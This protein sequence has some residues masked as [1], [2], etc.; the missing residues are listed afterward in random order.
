[1]F[2]N[3]PE[4]VKDISPAIEARLPIGWF[5]NYCD[6]YQELIEREEEKIKIPVV[7][8]QPAA[9]P[10][11]KGKGG[12]NQQLNQN[13]GKKNW[14]PAEFLKLLKKYE[15]LTSKPLEEPKEDESA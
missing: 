7:S 13:S 3:I 14:N 1:M 11:K 2:H 6:V 5:L 15:E 12:Y 10:P 9:N 8:P 4:E